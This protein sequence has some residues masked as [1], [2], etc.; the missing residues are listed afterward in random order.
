LLA[1]CAQ[2]WMFDVHLI[3]LNANDELQNILKKK[4]GTLK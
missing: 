4:I 2:F 1:N 3:D